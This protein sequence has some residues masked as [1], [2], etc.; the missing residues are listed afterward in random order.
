MIVFARGRLAVRGCSEARA[1]A[2]AGERVAKGTDKDCRNCAISSIASRI[3]QIMFFFPSLILKVATLLG[4]FKGC[5]RKL[6][7]QAI[8]PRDRQ[9]NFGTKIYRCLDRVSNKVQLHFTFQ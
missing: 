4:I 2:A 3:I 8:P 9:L 5:N 7:E 1:V 6:Q